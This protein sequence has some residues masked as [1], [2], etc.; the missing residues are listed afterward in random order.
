MLGRSV[1]KPA[2]PTTF[3]GKTYMPIP[4]NSITPS[5]AA[6]HEN[7]GSFTKRRRRGSDTLNLHKTALTASSRRVNEAQVTLSWCNPPHFCFQ[8]RTASNLRRCRRRGGGGC[9]GDWGGTVLRAAQQAGITGFRKPRGNWLSQ[10]TESQ[11]PGRASGL[12]LI[13]VSER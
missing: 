13:S 5:R 4:P 7:R 1:H 2:K 8:T 6:P 3:P 9:E 11:G 12:R 10:L